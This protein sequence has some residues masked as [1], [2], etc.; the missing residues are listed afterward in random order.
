MPRL[1]QAE[2]YTSQ[3][4]DAKF[5]EWYQNDG[6]E[7]GRPISAI[8]G[9]PEMTGREKLEM[10]SQG[11]I[12]DL[13]RY[14]TTDDTAQTLEELIKPKEYYDTPSIFAPPKGMK[15]LEIP[16]IRGLGGWYYSK[17]AK[18]LE[19]P[20]GRYAVQ[21]AK[22]KQKLPQGLIQRI[23]TEKKALGDISLETRSEI[24]ALTRRAAP[25]V[26][27]KPWHEMTGNEIREAAR[28]AG[29]NPELLE[30][31]KEA[32]IYLEANRDI[33]F[34]HRA[35]IDRLQELVRKPFRQQAKT[36]RRLGDERY[37]E[38]PTK[39]EK[40][41]LFQS[42]YFTYIKPFRSEDYR[43]SI[44]TALPAPDRAIMGHFGGVDPH[45]LGWAITT[46]VEPLED[47]GKKILT[48]SP[49]GSVRVTEPGK[50]FRLLSEAQG[51]WV[52]EWKKQPKVTE[53]ER[54]QIEEKI[55]SGR[56]LL[57][58]INEQRSAVA[59][60]YTDSIER[61]GLRLAAHHY[62]EGF[63][64]RDEFKSKLAARDPELPRLL[65]QHYELWE[66]K[67]A[68]D[69]ELGQLEG[70]LRLAIP[71]PPVQSDRAARKILFK[72]ALAESIAEGNTGFGWSKGKHLEQRYLHREF[73]PD[74]KLEQ[75][76]EEAG[77]F[78]PHTLGYY[79]KHRSL[80]RFYKRLY[81][82]EAPEIVREIFQE[83]GQAAPKI[84]DKLVRGNKGQP[85]DVHYVD[86]PKSLIDEFY[87]QKGFP[88]D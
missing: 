2:W 20:M 66:R 80:H 60:K 63:L 52:R 69:S 79:K 53:A 35:V 85:L 51:D 65:E 73:E 9:K 33:P 42:Q 37:P 21:G 8:T 68:V 29:V 50:P 14:L 44:V 47:P 13:A 76:L 71:L 26:V 30:Y 22:T 72:R 34:G 45:A 48:R 64:T 23:M 54:L 28:Q 10:I 81:D 4:E 62:A 43:E 18:L 82:E 7:Y 87:K 16:E 83:M 84:R 38:F 19:N 61:H 3:E 24:E 58:Q 41:A 27:E 77:E 49:T 12:G 5:R 31:N 86:L 56:E 1:S 40:E 17:F 6:Y 88:I 55:R 57:T 15:L 46:R 32:S 11:P 39:E 25:K 70:V 75:E 59:R 78:Y 74:P 36:S 67:Q